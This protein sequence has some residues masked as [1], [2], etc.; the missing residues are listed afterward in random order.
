MNPKVLWILYLCIHIL[1]EI[2]LQLQNQYSG[3]L[4]SSRGIHRA[5]KS[6]SHSM[7]TVFAGVQAKAML[8]FI[9]LYYH[10][11]VSF[12]WSIEYHIFVLFLVILLLTVAL[13]H[14][15]EVLSSIPKYKKA[16]VC[17]TEKI[18]I[19]HQLH[20]C[21]SYSVIGYKF[22]VNESTIYSILNKVCLNRNTHKQD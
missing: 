20:S 3:L 10:K 16:V 18:R 6:Q 11:Q 15:D 5:V 22:N 1:T 13:K 2:Y 7:Y 21:M 4:Q 9:S 17:L 8:C 19:L 12:L 14:S